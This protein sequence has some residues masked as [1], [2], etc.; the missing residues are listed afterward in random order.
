[1]SK[2]PLAPFEEWPYRVPNFDA[3]LKKMK[4]L[5]EEF[6]AAKSEEEA[7]KVYKKWNKLSDAFADKVTYIQVLFSL[8]TRVKKVKKA[9]DLLDRRLPE[10]SALNVEFAKAFLSSPY[11]PFFEKKVG[12][13]LFQMFEYSLKSFDPIIIEEAMKDND[14]ISKY[15]ALIASCSIEF[16]GKTYNLPQLSKFMQ[17]NDR[18]VRRRARLAYD[19]YLLTKK[20]EIEDIYDQMVKVRTKMAKTMGYKS[21]T[22]LAYNNM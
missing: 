6:K 3:T 12:P 8:D 7:Y 1:M 20:D 17:D 21:Y 15:N 16:E 22:E 4:E 9:N 19:N 2:K 18:D 10:V 13:F 11:R 14:L 5:V